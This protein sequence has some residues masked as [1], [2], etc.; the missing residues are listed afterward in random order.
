VEHRDNPGAGCVIAALSM[1]A[2]RQGPNV[3]AVFTAAA[4]RFLEF[5]GRVVPGRSPKTK[6]REALASLA[7][8][9]GAV[10]LARTISDA[11]L[12]EE[13][14]DAVHAKPTDLDNARPT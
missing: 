3:R 5:L 11:S 2:A 13:I 9:V 14:L 7:A 8:M 6:R 4:K 12:S 10:V 1:E